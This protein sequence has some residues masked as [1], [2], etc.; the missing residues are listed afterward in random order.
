MLLPLH[1]KYRQV[2]GIMVTHFIGPEV[3]KLENITHKILQIFRL[4]DTGKWFNRGPEPNGTTM[5]VG[6]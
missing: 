4:V 1:A 2:S 5:D 6:T 3:K